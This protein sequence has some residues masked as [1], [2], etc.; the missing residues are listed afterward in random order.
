MTYPKQLV[1]FRPT[2]GL[3]VDLPP[4]EVGPEFYTG[5]SNLHF[6][7]GFCQ[8]TQGEAQVYGTLASNLRNILNLQDNGGINYWV[9]SG[10]DTVTKIT[11]ALSNDITPAAG[12]TSEDSPDQF[13]TGLLNG[14]MHWNNGIDPPYWQDGSPDALMEVLPGWPVGDTCQS[15]R[16]FKYHLFAMDISTSGG[17]FPMQVKWSASAPP[18][19]IPTEWAATAA[20]DSG[21]TQLSDMPGPIID[22]APL[23]G[24]FIIYKN[25]SCYICDYVG[26]A[27]VFSFRKL[28]VTNGV[29]ARNC[30]ADYQGRHYVLGADDIYVHDGNTIKSLLDDRARSAVFDA[31]DQENYRNSF[32]L[33]YEKQKEIWFCIPT[34]S[35]PNGFAN[36]AVIY[37]LDEDAWSSR[38][39]VSA[40]HGFVGLVND[41]A[42]D[43]SWD[44]DSQAWDLDVTNW[45]E[46]GFNIAQESL[47]Y[48]STDEVTPTD[49]RL[50]EVDTGSD[51]AGQPILANVQKYG[52][53]FDEPD[54]NKIVKRCYPKFTANDGVAIQIRV[55]G[56]QNVD[57][58]ITWSNPVTV[59][60]GGLQRA[61]LF[62]QGKYI[63]FEASS[64]GGLPWQMT[65]FDLEVEMRGYF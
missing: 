25:R 57:G 17:D 21:D 34:A 12:L 19:A 22:G 20:N 28:F 32:V 53:H 2:Q 59:T 18:G 49:S 64:Q 35:S 15:M 8:R 24:S 38:L 30:I 56:S 55:G 62:A 44:S 48:A 47:V 9:Y 1:Q 3:N 54:R 11:A 60:K 51:F 6:R 10:A 36:V 5:G 16:A 61:D 40:A 29:M 27:F 50:V 45:Q 42:P 23:R 37:N 13:T 14:L 39:I 7:E 26:G 33:N 4:S 58:T 43:D 41:Q 52:M 63:S 31:L 65:G 46:Q